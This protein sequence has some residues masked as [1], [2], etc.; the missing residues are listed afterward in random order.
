MIY[1]ISTKTN[2]T[3]TTIDQQQPF[4][5]VSSNPLE[6]QLRQTLREPRFSS[7]TITQA[8]VKQ[9]L[10]NTAYAHARADY[11]KSLLTLPGM[12]AHARNTILLNQQIQ[13]LRLANHELN[14]DAFQTLLGEKLTEILITLKENKQLDLS[15]YKAKSEHKNG[16]G[17][18]L[19]YSNP[20]TNAPYCLQLFVFLPKQ[21]N[22]LAAAKEI[23]HQRGHR[24]TLHNHI[25][26]CASHVLE[27]TLEETLYRPI[28]GFRKNAPLALETKRQ[29]R[30]TG[31]AEGFDEDELNTVHR[32]ENIGNTT[33]ISVHYY[34]E[35]DGIQTETERAANLRNTS[36]DMTGKAN[37]ANQYRAFKAHKPAKPVS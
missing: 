1:S 33:A 31:S 15:H 34:R 36:A 2:P 14:E 29:I 27:G 13:T 20:D 37:V 7:G 22:A 19:L 4:T 3:T 6:Q 18:Y 9:Y 23:N 26:P 32:L 8:D 30:E 11:E 12:V 28:E 35:M 21:A 5:V 17:K 16:Y 24:T 10:D 25:A